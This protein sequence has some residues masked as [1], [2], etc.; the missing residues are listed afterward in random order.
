MQ[1]R[2]HDALRGH[3]LQIVLVA[4]AQLGTALIL[5][6]RHIV[7]GALDGD[8]SL[9]VKTVDV[10]DRTDGDLCVRVLH[11][12]LHCRPALS[13][14]P[15]NQVVVGQNFQEHFTEMRT[16]SLLVKIWDSYSHF[17]PLAS[18][19]CL[20]LHH[21]QDAFTSVRTVLGIPVDGDCLLQRSHVL[22]PVHIHA[23][24]TLLCDLTDGGSLA[25]NDRAH[26]LTLHEQ[27]QRKIGLASWT[28]HASAVKLLA[29]PR[30]P[31]QLLLLF[32]G[33]CLQ[34]IPL[35]LDA[36]QAGGGPV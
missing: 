4:L 26:H 3:R 25:A 16:T 30:V 27:P 9:K 22:L 13:D 10:V 8:D 21:L 17:S 2:E 6:T 7:N 36:V 14:D 19:G 20:H 33:L 29:I 5:R 1:A 24:P 11:D 31:P 23:S 32:H 34:L 35:E 15:S 18:V 28:G 12:A